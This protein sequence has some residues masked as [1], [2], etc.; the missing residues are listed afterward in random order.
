MEQQKIRGSNHPGKP[1]PVPESAPGRGGR[2]FTSSRRVRPGKSEEVESEGGICPSDVG[3]NRR[4][5]G[6]KPAPVGRRAEEERRLAKCWLLEDEVASQSSRIIKRRG[7]AA[8]ARGTFGDQRTNS[9]ERP[10]LHQSEY[11]LQ[12][13]KHSLIPTFLERTSRI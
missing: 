9:I 10:S 12:V 4:R 1:S 11:F 13:K 2:D 7:G 8:D 5:G 3:I 6:A